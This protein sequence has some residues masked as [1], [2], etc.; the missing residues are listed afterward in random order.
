MRIEVKFVAK[1][2]E[3]TS[4]VWKKIVRCFKLTQKETEELEDYNLQ[5]LEDYNL[6][7][8]FRIEKVEP[9]YKD[10]KL[11]IELPVIFGTLKSKNI[12]KGWGIKLANPWLIKKFKEDRKIEIESS[13][14]KRVKIVTKGMIYLKVPSS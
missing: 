4:S 8:L 5:E 10:E 6:Q 12:F 9:K 11:R 14:S 3:T 7:T 1:K 13:Y 2:K